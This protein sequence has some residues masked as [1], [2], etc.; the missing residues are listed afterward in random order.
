M[1]E[2]GNHRDQSE[3]ELD[4]QVCSWLGDLL[5]K[6]G[7]LADQFLSAGRKELASGIAA[8]MRKILGGYNHLAK[9]ADFADE[10]EWRTI[11]VALGTESI[12]YEV[13]EAGVVRRYVDGPS[14]K[15]GLS[16]ESSITVGPQVPN[17]GAAR[18]YVEHLARKRGLDLP[19]VNLSK[20]TYRSAP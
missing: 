10:S 13:D 16:S 1:D 20:Q 18:A 7:D 9:S 17:G 4:Q 11:D 12:S 14:L 3:K 5:K 15:L 6:G 19:N 2:L 8:R